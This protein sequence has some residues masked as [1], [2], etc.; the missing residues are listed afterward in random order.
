MLE[1]SDDFFL[2]C[3]TERNSYTTNQIELSPPPTQSAAQQTARP[4]KE[5][6][7]TRFFPCDRLLQILCTFI[8]S[9]DTDRLNKNIKNTP[10]LLMIQPS[11]A[12]ATCYES[13][14]STR[15]GD[16]NKK[17]SLPL[18]F[19]ILQKASACKIYHRQKSPCRAKFRQAWRVGSQENTKI[20]SSGNAF[21]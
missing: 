10:T 1:R 2:S 9:P 13:V 7:K 18:F 20:F 16:R 12:G 6:G 21:S 15:S 5:G 14:A 3:R 11:A 17:C 8:P 19:C 4:S